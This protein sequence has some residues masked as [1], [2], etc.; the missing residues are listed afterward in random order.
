MEEEEGGG[1]AA[2]VLCA[3]SYSLDRLSAE[4]QTYIQD[5]ERG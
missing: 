4:S 3:D 5:M 1:G 2:L